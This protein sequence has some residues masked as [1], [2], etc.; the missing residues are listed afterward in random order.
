METTPVV[1]TAKPAQDIPLTL[2]EERYAEL[3]VAKQAA[4]DAQSLIS[5]LGDALVELK[6]QVATA[7]QDHKRALKNVDVIKEGLSELFASDMRN[8]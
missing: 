6:K 2:F 7:D 3:K 5:K 4:R 1:E 8:Y